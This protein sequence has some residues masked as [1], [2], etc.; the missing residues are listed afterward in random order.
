MSQLLTNLNSL[1]VHIPWSTLGE[2]LLASGVLSAFL[3]APYHFIKKWF[4][5]HS[6]VMIVVVGLSGLAVSGVNYLLKTPTTDPTIVA[7]QGFAIAF[8]TQPFYK[9]MLKPLFAWL[10][11]LITAKVEKAVEYNAELKS[12]AIPVTLAKPQALP[13][14]DFSQ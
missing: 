12:A 14:Q 13:I 7:L 8:G 6:E 4:E 2:G 11:S 9:L 1:A 3:T 5:H 10:T